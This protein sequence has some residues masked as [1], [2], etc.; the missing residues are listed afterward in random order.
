[1]LFFFFF[2]VLLVNSRYFLTH[3]IRNDCVMFSAMIFGSLGQTCPSQVCPELSPSHNS[4]RERESWGQETDY[5]WTNQDQIL[6]GWI[7]ILPLQVAADSFERT[8]KSLVG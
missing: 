3:C 7:Q 2:C 1:M 6:D 4:G 5:Q 8:L